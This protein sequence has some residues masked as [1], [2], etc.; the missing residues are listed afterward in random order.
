MPTWSPQQVP[1]QPKPHERQT[2]SSVSRDFQET[3]GLLDSL[4]RL[5]RLSRDSWPSPEGENVNRIALLIVSFGQF[6][7]N[8]EFLFLTPGFINLAFLLFPLP[9]YRGFNFLRS[10]N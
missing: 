6:T 10:L 3:H 7:I 4:K 1:G 2:L 8:S 5:K 9:I